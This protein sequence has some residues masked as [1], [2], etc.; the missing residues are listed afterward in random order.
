MGASVADTP[1]LGRHDGG[2]HKFGK[3][4]SDQEET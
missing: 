1:S 3:P 2:G 4:A